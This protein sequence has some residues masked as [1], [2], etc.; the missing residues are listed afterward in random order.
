MAITSLDYLLIE[1]LKWDQAPVILHKMQ[2][3][4][5]LTVFVLLFFKSKRVSFYKTLW[6]AY[7]GVGQHTQSWSR[8][9]K[10][11][12]TVQIHCDL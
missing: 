10:E 8:G 3:C 11:N 4:I 9:N 1:K 5:I 12:M 6:S 7:P 2:I